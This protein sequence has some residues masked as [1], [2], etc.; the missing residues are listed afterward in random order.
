MVNN[1]ICCIVVDVEGRKCGFTVSKK[2]REPEN[3]PLF[4]ETNFPNLPNP[5]FEM[6]LC[7]LG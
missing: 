6:G 1:P 5:L 7:W 3:S 4:V 2:N